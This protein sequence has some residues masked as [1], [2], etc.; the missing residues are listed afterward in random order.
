MAQ[1]FDELETRSPDERRGA[2]ERAL[3]ETVRFAWDRSDAWRKRLDEARIAPAGI[4]SLE[5]LP[6]IPVLTKDDLRRQQAAA[7]PF[8]GFLTTNLGDLPRMF[9][10]PGPLYDPQHGEVDIGGFARGLYAA[11][12]RPGMLVLNSFTYHLTPA[13]HALESGAL[14]IGAT[15]IPGGVGN[16]EQQVEVLRDCPVDGYIG[17][18]SF[19][20]ILLER[21][22]EWRF[23][24]ACVA[25]EKINEQDR[26]SLERRGDSVRQVYGTADLG[27][28]AAEC[29]VAQGMHVTEDKLVEIV[30]P[31]SG[32]PAPTGGIG[33]V[34]V[35][36]FSQIYPMLRF[37]TGDLSRWR[38]EE[39]CE[40]GRTS[41]RIDGV[42]GRVGEGV[43]VRG[44]FVYPHHVQ[45]ALSG[46]DGL[47]ELVIDREGQQDVVVLRVAGD[48]GEDETEA[49][50]H[51]FRELAKVRA[52]VERVG[53]GDIASPGVI[54]DV[55]DVWE[56]DEA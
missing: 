56:G 14:A 12:I 51:R 47:G 20:S 48:L 29:E 49:I 25:A 6:A 31:V 45:G 27:H 55:R 13:G 39:A 34:V 23:I 22:P 7:P 4:R 38:T 17:T 15:V 19:L 28:I 52:V 5:D 16:T 21:A 36:T 43:K 41:P 10:S 32:A 53:E 37:G 8:G 24:R 3:S 1:F 9:V 54:R 30:D 26:A 2:L 40:C 35:T 18:P 50:G 42:L 44:M 46:V 33:Q 11:G